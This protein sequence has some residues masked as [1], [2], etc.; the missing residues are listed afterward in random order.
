MIIKIR[1]N[2]LHTEEVIQYV[3]EE[4]EVD[5]NQKQRQVEQH[6]VSIFKKQVDFSW[7][8]LSKFTGN[9]DRGGWITVEVINGRNFGLI[10]LLLG[11]S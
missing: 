10:S 9:G 4:L 7:K 3:F 1:N 8:M 5:Y 6:Q 11:G 2:F